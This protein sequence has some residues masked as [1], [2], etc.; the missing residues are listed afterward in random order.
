MVFKNH[1]FP[2]RIPFKQRQDMLDYDFGGD[3]VTGQG[4]GVEL[5]CYTE[6]SKLA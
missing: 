4:V 2:L 1:R 3:K 6:I 5:L